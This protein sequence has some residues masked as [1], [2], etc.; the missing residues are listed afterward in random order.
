MSTTESPPPPDEKV[1]VVAHARWSYLP[2]R[3]SY[4]FFVGIAAG[5]ALRLLYL[6]QPGDAFAPMMA[7]FIYLSPLVVGAV[8][9]YVAERTERRSVGYYFAAPLLANVF[10]VFGTLVIMIEG[11]ICVL[12]IVPLFALLGA[13]GGLLMGAV[14]RL[15]NWPKQTLGCLAALPLILGGFE[16]HVPL[17]D[18]IASVERTRLV[19]APPEAVWAEI[20]NARD[21]RR[22]E[23][24]HAWIYRIGVPTPVMGVTERRDG[25]AV[26]HITMGKG[27]H[28][29]QVAETWDPPRR[30]S[31]R[32]RF[33]DDSFPK[34]ALDQHVTIGGRYFDLRDTEYTLVPRGGATELRIRMGYRVTTPFNWYAAPMARWLIG[35]FEE[36]IL[37]FYERRALAA[38]A[39]AG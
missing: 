25:V 27:I 16:Q 15:T 24:D 6:G 32:Y 3:S 10:Y 36:T 1:V 26:R 18:R 13:V 5:I 11:L 35:D 30:A 28:F 8:T 22:D 21:I 19:A 39:T 34:Y 37:R 20:E 23:V 33:T 4:P 14:C 29:D 2:F 31:F 17:P 38:A 12:L 9:V 7:S